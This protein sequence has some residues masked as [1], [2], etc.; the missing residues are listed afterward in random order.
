MIAALFFLTPIICACKGEL[1][2]EAVSVS[3]QHKQNR[4]SVSS[5]AE[6]HE[7]LGEWGFVKDGHRMD[8]QV[9]GIYHSDGQEKVAF[10]IAG[11]GFTAPIRS[12][13]CEGRLCTLVFEYEN[14][15]YQ[16]TIYKI[17]FRSI[18]NTEVEIVDA[19][20]LLHS[21]MLT[22]YRFRRGP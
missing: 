14:P 18:S 3:K 10:D 8:D 2:E 4:N 9:L 21:M 19:P 5:S 12:F 13:S 16:E 11:M 15:D 22:G 17:V 20:E 1:P 7:Y 6:L